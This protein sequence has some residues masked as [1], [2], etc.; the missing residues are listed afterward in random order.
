MFIVTIPEDMMMYDEDSYSE[1]WWLREDVFTWL[2]EMIGEG[3]QGG[4]MYRGDGRELSWV[5]SFGMGDR[6]PNPVFPCIAFNNKQD[7]AAFK[8]AWTNGTR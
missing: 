3:N 8:L 6:R 5:L 7:A 4:G 1:G 2:K